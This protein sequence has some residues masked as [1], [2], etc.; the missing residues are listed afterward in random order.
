M[1]DWRS[2]A[3]TFVWTAARSRPPSQVI[4]RTVATFTTPPSITPAYLVEDQLTIGAQLHVAGHRVVERDLVTTYG[5]H[6]VGG[7]LATLLGQG[8][9]ATIVVDRALSQPVRD[10]TLHALARFRDAD[11]AELY[12]TGW[13]R[14]EEHG[15]QLLLL[16]H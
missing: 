12:E 3:L 9:D 11:P 8:V 14:T 5:L 13:E 1:D 15:W 16:Q 10:A 6:V 2:R 7:V 4:S